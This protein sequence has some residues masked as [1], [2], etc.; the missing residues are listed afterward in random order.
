MGIIRVPLD[1]NI[2][3]ELRPLTKSEEKAISDFIQVDKEKWKLNEE[4]KQIIKRKSK[5][6][7]L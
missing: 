2:I 3:V 7:V 5:Q 6:L 4:T 1:M